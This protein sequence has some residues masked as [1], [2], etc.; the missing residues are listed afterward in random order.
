M[1]KEKPMGIKELDEHC[2]MFGMKVLVKNGK[3]YGIV[4][5]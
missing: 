5:D 1:N 3:W 4:R 2:K